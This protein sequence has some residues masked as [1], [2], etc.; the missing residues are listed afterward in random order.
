METVH[1]FICRVKW[2]VG[3]AVAICREREA[4][5]RQCALDL[6]LILHRRHVAR[7]TEQEG[8]KQRVRRGHL[9]IQP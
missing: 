6:A 3:G 2:R 7:L 1:K 9:L 5:E 8:E 4:R